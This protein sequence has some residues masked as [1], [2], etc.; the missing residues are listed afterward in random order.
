MTKI[1]AVEKK[2]KSQPKLDKEMQ[3]LERKKH[4]L[5]LILAAGLKG[6][7]IRLRLTQ[8]ELAEKAN[9]TARTICMLE[10]KSGASCSMDTF[11]AVASVMDM[12]VLIENAAKVI[13][14][15][16]PDNTHIPRRVVSKRKKPESTDDG[17]TAPAM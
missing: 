15:Q 3:I 7:R 6:A 14:G 16:D 17:Q 2:T 10:S 8:G 4:T 13:D 11:L 1:H 12:K 9:V 5:K